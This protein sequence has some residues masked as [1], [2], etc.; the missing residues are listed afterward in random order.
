MNLIPTGRDLVTELVLRVLGS[1]SRRSR[2]HLNPSR[3][4]K[5]CMSRHC[6]SVRGSLEAESAAG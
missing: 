1:R 4:S 3:K 5:M 2:S 6:V